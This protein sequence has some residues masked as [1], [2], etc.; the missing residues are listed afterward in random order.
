ME[1]WLLDDFQA[2]VD[3]EPTPYL[4]IN[5]AFKAVAIP[6]AGTYRIEFTYWPR[7]FSLCLVL[8][9]V[10]L[11]GGGLLWIFIGSRASHAEATATKAA[12]F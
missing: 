10:G 4:R 9:A 1:P 6:G 5:H 3:G 2:S 8:A 12:A 11:V 7:G